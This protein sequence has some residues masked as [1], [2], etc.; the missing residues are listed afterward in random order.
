VEKEHKFWLIRDMR[1]LLLAMMENFSGG[2]HISLRGDLKA[3]GLSGI[4]GASKDETETLK[5]NSTWPKQDFVVLPLESSTSKTIVSAVGGTIPKSIIH[6]Q[7]EKAGSIQFAAYDNFHPQCIVFHPAMD[8]A[9]LE[10]LV[11]E[12]VISPYT[13]RLPRR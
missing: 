3:L 1:R 4:P 9:I 12:G 13:E 5:R 11:S 10:S 6:V 2:A 8:K 7:I